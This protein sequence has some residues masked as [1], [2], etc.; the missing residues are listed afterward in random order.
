MHLT[1]SFSGL[2]PGWQLLLKLH[3]SPNGEG[4][5]LN[6]PLG[7][8]MSFVKILPRPALHR[9]LF[10]LSNRSTRFLSFLLNGV[11]SSCLH[12]SPGR[13]IAFSSESTCQPTP[14]SAE[15]PWQAGW[16]D[17]A[18]EEGVSPD[19]C[20]PRHITLQIFLGR[21]DGKITQGDPGFP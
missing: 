8:S 3:T 4:C 7:N 15:V 9:E 18:E 10:T 17:S 12:L 21:H 19:T 13:Y 14:G 2:L 20:R 1:V 16:Q 5:R 11:S 6:A